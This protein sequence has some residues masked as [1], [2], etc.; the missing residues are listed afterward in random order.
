KICPQ[1]GLINYPR[2]SP[3]VIVAVVKNGQILLARNKQAR[4][5]FYSVL[6]G[7]VEP[8]ETLEQ[9]VEREVGEEVGI[10]VENI[11]YFGSQPWPFPNSLM[12]GFTAEYASGEIQIDSGELSD[13]GWFDKN[14]LPRVPPALSIA[15][16]LI[17]W[18]VKNRSI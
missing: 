9:C 6:A 13:A 17:E 4:I 2:V 1:C 16:Q 18:F 14:S 3:A 5:P 7:F 15:G 8:S 10:T 12:I 11:R